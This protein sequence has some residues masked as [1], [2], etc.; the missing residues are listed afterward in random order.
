MRLDALVCQVGSTTGDDRIVFRHKTIPKPEHIV[1][2]RIDRFPGR[3]LTVW[4]FF[5]DNAEGDQVFNIGGANV[6]A[7]ADLSGNL[8]HTGSTGCNRGNNRIV[9]RRFPYLLLE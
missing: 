7:F 8:R 5:F 3:F 6:G 2:N 9:E 1:R 4:R